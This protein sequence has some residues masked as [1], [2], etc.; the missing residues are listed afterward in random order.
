MPSLKPPAVDPGHFD[1]AAFY[2]VRDMLFRLAD[3]ENPW[4]GREDE[5]LVLPKGW[6]SPPPEGLYAEFKNHTQPII[7][8]AIAAGTFGLDLETVINIVENTKTTRE[9][10]EMAASMRVLMGGS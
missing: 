2:R 1:I 7:D 4:T 8:R 3:G 10:A 5:L 6:P 9:A